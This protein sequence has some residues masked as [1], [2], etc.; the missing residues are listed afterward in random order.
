MLE[1]GDLLALHEPLEGL[2]FIGPLRLG[3]RTFESPPQLL[4]WLLN[5]TRDRA[6]FLKE[7]VNP[8]VQEIVLNDRRFLTEVHHAFLIRRPAEVAASWYALEHDMRIYDTGL[9]GLRDLYV[10]VRSAEGHAPVVIDSDDLVARPAA[11]MAAYCAAVGLPFIGD[12]LRWE[13]GER[14]EWVRSSRW[15][16]DASASRGFESPKH[17]DRHALG[18]HPDV[19][20]FARRHTPFYE[21]LRSHR[22]DVDSASSV[23]SDR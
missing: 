21:E 8:P 1:R 12:A 10:A 13:P 2:H 18:S 9:E 20:S 7:T 22:L 17:P 11:T 4:S 23:D 14:P 19:V 5:D 16:L 6:V 3:A 15:H